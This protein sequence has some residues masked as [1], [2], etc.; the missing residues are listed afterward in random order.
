VWPTAARAQQTAMPV[1]GLLS[2]VSFDAYA[3]RL[4]AFRQGLAAGGFIEGQNLVVEYR[5]AEGDAGR[6]P[7]L[8]ADLVGRKVS[9]IVGIAGD[10]PPYAARATSTIPIVFAI[11]NDPT[12]GGLVKNLSRPEANLTGVSFNYGSLA[13]KRLELLHELVPSANSIGFL[14][15]D[16]LS[17]LG[18]HLVDDIAAARTLGVHLVVLDA[19]TEKQ[20]DAAF[21]TMSQQRVTALT[22]DNDAYLNT[23]KEQIIGLA[24]RRAIPTMYAYREHSLAG[25]L[26][27]YGTD[28]LLMYRQAASY[29]ARI[30]KGEKPADLPVQL[31]T[32]FELIINL[33][34]AKTLGLTVPQSILLR[35]D[36]VIE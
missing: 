24:A 9:V 19:G 14:R 4:T 25:G 11:G 23:R 30:L 31:P 10:S 20:I 35:A 21:D 34:T 2:G 12:D 32:R 15:N 29:T 17:G 13:P 6:L 5:S 8:A 1:I 3:A 18:N 28:V 16:R 26:I 27:S 22:V 7:A 36:E 33:K